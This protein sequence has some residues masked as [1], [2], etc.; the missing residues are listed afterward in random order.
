MPAL[1]A[2]VFIVDDDASVRRSLARLVKSAGYAAETFASA[3]EFL[4]S[5]RVSKG[6]GCLVLDIQMPGLNGLELQQELARLASSLPIIFI[7]GHG[8][9]PTS[10]RAMKAGAVDFLP[11][12]FQDTDLL[13]AVATALERNVHERTDY[14]A[15]HQIQ[16]HLDK[17]TPREREV[18]LLV[19][20]GKLNKQIADE[21]G[22]SLP[23]VK[24][25]RGRVMQKMG[26][27]SLAELVHAAEMVGLLASGNDRTSV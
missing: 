10:V 21:L 7:T 23:T 15:K 2:T 27:A 17:L 5:D 24:I 13:R 19:I 16:Q 26:I 22:V 6:P 3:R 9:I 14:A 18:L 20:T 8:D 11:K 4:D 12:P 1:G 25:H